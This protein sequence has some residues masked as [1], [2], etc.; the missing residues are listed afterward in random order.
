MTRQTLLAAAICLAF[1]PS[2]Q[3]VEAFDGNIVLGRPT[4]TSISVN[5][6]GL[7]DQ[8]VYVEYGSRPGN[9]DYTTPAAN[10]R[11]NEPHVLE[12]T[13]LEPDAGYSYRLR[14]RN[15]GDGEFLDAAPADFR[16]QRARGSAYTFAV[17]ADSHMGAMTRH[18]KWCPT[19]GREL[20]DDVTFANTMLNIVKY[21]PDF[22]VGGL[23]NPF[24][25]S[26][27]GHI[28]AEYFE[29]GGRTPFDIEN[30]SAPRG[31]E[32]AENWEPR[33]RVDLETE[34]YDFDEHRPGW[35]VPIHRMLVDNGVNVVFHGHDH[36]Y[37]KEVHRDGIIDQAVA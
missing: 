37:V 8:E 18:Q 1:V 12:L 28:Y 7:S 33:P 35:G 5:V 22:L 14:F 34:S 15:P 4:N 30:W 9:Y 2:V 16:T 21:N 32:A 36:V 17:Q 10:L 3:A 25:G 24:A 6:L 27:G 19:C 29:W 13:G 11:A 31:P 20:A 23:D 26:R